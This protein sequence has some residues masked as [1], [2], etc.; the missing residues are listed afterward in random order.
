MS[1]GLWV[2]YKNPADY[3]GKYVLRKWEITAGTVAPERAVVLADD[4]ETLRAQLPAGVQRFEPDKL[5][6][7]SIVE[8]YV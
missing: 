8:C 1:L 7:V 6:N 2:I 4:I 5:D 3:P